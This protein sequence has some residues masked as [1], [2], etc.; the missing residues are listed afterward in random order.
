M[1]DEL[2]ITDYMQ[3]SLDLVGIVADLAGRNPAFI[4]G[5]DARFECYFCRV[6]C[7]PD[8]LANQLGISDHSPDCLWRRARLAWQIMLDEDAA[9]EAT[10]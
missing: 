3:R 10:S 8:T 5:I 9:S 4:A 2:S 6:D 1:T 7:D